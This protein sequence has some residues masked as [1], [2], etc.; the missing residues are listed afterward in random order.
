VIGIP[1]ILIIIGFMIIFLGNI[2]ETITFPVSEAE[3]QRESLKEIIG[4]ENSIYQIFGIMIF[5]GGIVD[6]S[7]RLKRQKKHGEDITSDVFF[8]CL[9]GNR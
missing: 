8:D 7:R 5:S 4:L 9:L 1:I 2:L 3:N 6:L